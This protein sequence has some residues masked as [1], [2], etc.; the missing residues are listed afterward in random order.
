[1]SQD[2]A[3]NKFDLVAFLYLR[4]AHHLCI[5]KPPKIFVFV[6][7]IRDPAGHAGREILACS[8]KNNDAAAGHI[9]AAVIANAF[10]DGVCSAVTNR[11][12]FTRDA[13]ECFCTLVSASRTICNSSIEVSGSPVSLISV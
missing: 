5:A 4:Q 12:S 8:S 6:K 2:Q 3:L 7:H 1:M 13:R 11:K 10:D 9:F